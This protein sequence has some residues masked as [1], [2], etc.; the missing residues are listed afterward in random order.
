MCRVVL[1]TPVQWQP[2]EQVFVHLHQV[3]GHVFVAG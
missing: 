3:L 2:S 1:V